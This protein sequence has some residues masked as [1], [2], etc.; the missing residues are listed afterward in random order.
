MLT[1][2]VVRQR[3]TSCVS[4][5]QMV[6]LL[7]CTQLLTTLL[8]NNDLLKSTLTSPVEQYQY[9]SPFWGVGLRVLHRRGGSNLQARFTSRRNHS[10]YSL[11]QPP[12]YGT[13]LRTDT[14][15]ICVGRQQSQVVCLCTENRK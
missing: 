12:T 11:S 8:T 13:A 3:F 1:A 5:K 9:F 2:A 6:L 7:E 15:R 10:I 14:R 4:Q